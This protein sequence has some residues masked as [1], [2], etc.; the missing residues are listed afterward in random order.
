MDYEDIENQKPS[1][2]EGLINEEDLK[3][4][5][6]NHSTWSDGIHTLEEMAIHVR[7]SGYEYFGICDHSQS[8]FYANGLQ[9]L[10]HWSPAL[11]FFSSLL[12]GSGLHFRFS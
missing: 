2:W 7:D 8:A 11:L 5:I 6:H 3:G 1:F 12:N 4:I 9:P 10:Y